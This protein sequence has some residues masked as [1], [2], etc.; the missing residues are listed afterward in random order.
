MCH[1]LMDLSH[2]QFVRHIIES[3]STHLHDIA[4]V[5]SAQSI[6]LFQQLHP[7]TITG[8]A[9][10]CLVVLAQLKVRRLKVHSFVPEIFLIA[11]VISLG[12]HSRK[13]AHDHVPVS[14]ILKHAADK[15]R[16]RLHHRA[17]GRHQP[18]V[19]NGA[20]SDIVDIRLV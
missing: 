11:H 20:L 10:A 4:G 7:G 5:V 16:I 14:Q 18:A 8:I 17:D 3:V 6:G 1:C 12:I 13:Q 15:R 2:G 19:A 9:P